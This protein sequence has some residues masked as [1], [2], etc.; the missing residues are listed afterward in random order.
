MRNKGAFLLLLFF[1]SLCSQQLY[2]P[3]PHTSQKCQPITL[4]MCKDAAYNMTMMPNLLGHTT[5]EDSAQ[6][7]SQFN[8]LM[9]VQ[10]SEDIK[11]FL[12][13]LHVPLCYSLSPVLNQ[14]IQPCRHLCL[15]ARKGCES[16]MLKFGFRWPEQMECSLFPQTFCVG[17]NRTRSEERRD[18]LECPTFM[19]TPFNTGYALELKSS[20]LDDCSLSCEEDNMMIDGKQRSLLRIWIAVWAGVS[21]ISSIFTIFTFLIDLPRFNYPVRPILYLAVCYTGIAVIYLIGASNGNKYACSKGVGTS[22]IVTQRLSNLKCTIMAL[23]FYLC[24][25]GAAAWWLVL[26]LSWFLAARLQWGNESIASLSIY[27]HAFGWGVP[28]ILSLLLLITESMDG[29]VFS[30]VCSVGNL[31]GDAVFHLMVIPQSMAILIGL[32]LLV[33]GI[34]SM[35]HIR[36]Y[37]KVR[38]ALDEDLSKLEKLMIRISL[39][40]LLFTIP[41]GVGCVI[42]GYEWRRMPIWMETSLFRPTRPISSDHPDILILATKYLSQLL[43]GITSAVWVMSP[44]TRDSYERMYQRVYSRLTGRADTS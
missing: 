23:F 8:P 32:I 39:F 35:I 30:G 40:A 2:Q 16:L 41:T 7:M 4:P 3:S 25:N 38:Q 26:C 14:I 9:K 42:G 24:T 29:D 21:F 31:N 22:L 11:L 34:S 1:P 28:S 19:R 43:V 18:N 37:Y 44:K 17:E 20:R 12:C 27:F 10:C 5:Q 36:S 13:T 15:S 6:A 33:M